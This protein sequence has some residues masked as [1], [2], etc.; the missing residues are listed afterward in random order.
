[1]TILASMNTHQTFTYAKPLANMKT[2]SAIIMNF[3]RS[4]L[5]IKY[6]ERYA[7]TKALAESTV[8]TIVQRSLLSSS[9]VP[10]LVAR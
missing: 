5:C 10:K 7:L 1:M 9:G 8:T 6:Y 2:R 4:I 3:L